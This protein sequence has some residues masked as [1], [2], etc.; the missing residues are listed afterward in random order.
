S[1]AG[2]RLEG[3]CGEEEAEARTAAAGYRSGEAAAEEHQDVAL[4]EGTDALPHAVAVEAVGVGGRS[5]FDRDRSAALERWRHFTHADSHGGY[6]LG[7]VRA[8]FHAGSGGE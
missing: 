3:R 7:H 5:E 1:G 2:D 8:G 4:E 6:R